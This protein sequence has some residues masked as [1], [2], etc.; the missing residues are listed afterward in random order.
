MPNYY[1]I[2]LG[3]SHLQGKIYLDQAITLL[4]DNRLLTILSQSETE[5]SGGVGT[6]DALV[7]TNAAICISTNLSPSAL[8]FALTSIETRLGRIR[9]MINGPR[10]LDLDLLWWSGRDYCDV[11]I[12]LPHPRF[13]ERKFAIDLALQALR[14]ASLDATSIKMG[15]DKGPRTYQAVTSI[16]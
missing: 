16:T 4:R 8:W 2:G 10:T 6:E 7:F 13:Q 12:T 5:L 14:H 1:I 11:F 9:T 3:S 15:A